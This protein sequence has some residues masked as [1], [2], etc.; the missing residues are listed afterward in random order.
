MFT[1]ILFI[2]LTFAMSFFIILPIMQSKGRG[3]V[4]FAS[5]SN[6]RANDLVERKETIYAAIKDIEFDYEMG[7]LSEED[8]KELRQ[9]YKDDAVKLLKK[10]DQIESKR[11]KARNIQSKHKKKDGTVNYCWICGTA[12][13]QDDKFCADCGNPLT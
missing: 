3:G 12:A 8:F 6:H 10:I 13:T 5:D 11:V 4:R 7:K 1:L 9:K 2:L